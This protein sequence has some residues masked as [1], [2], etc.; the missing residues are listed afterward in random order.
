MRGNHIGSKMLEEPLH[1]ES[2]KYQTGPWK[3]W[4]PDF[5][6]KRQL[7]VLNEIDN[8]VH[9][10][11][12]GSSDYSLMQTTFIK[13]VVCAYHS[14]QPMGNTKDE[15]GTRWALKAEKETR[16]VQKEC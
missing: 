13:Y 4:S 7:S 15:G 10:E 12:I 11:N 16:Q 1:L 3:P 9:G 2:H 8:D 5:L 6:K 14:A